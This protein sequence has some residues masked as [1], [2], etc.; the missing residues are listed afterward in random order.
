MP[1]W[2]EN[3]VDITFKDFESYKSCLDALDNQDGNKGFLSWILPEPE[4]KESDEKGSLPEW[5][6]WRTEHWGCKWEVDA[7]IVYQ[8]EIDL[9]LTLSF[10]SPWSP[11]IEAYEVLEERVAS[12]RGWYCEIGMMFCGV[13][14]N[15]VDSSYSIPDDPDTAE[16]LIPM[17]IL[18]MFDI[19]G[20]LESWKEESDLLQEA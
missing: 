17:S 18:D 6:S 5:Y 4:Y 16:D 8:H 10:N 15:G 1:N 11:P 7:I 20:M 3:I 9:K 12:V 19:I 14:S 2:C 13:F